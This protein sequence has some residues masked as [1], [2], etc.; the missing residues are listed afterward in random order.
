MSFII[1]FF[2]CPFNGNLTLTC[3]S[4]ILQSLS[5]RCYNAIIVQWLRAFLI[6]IL[7]T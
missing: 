1:V 5:C 3:N 4:A 6:V 2:H 7:Q